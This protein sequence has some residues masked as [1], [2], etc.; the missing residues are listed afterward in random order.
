MEVVIIT[1][2]YEGENR[3]S[4][5]LE[6]PLTITISTIVESLREAHWLSMNEELHYQISLTGEGW[7]DV[8]HQCLL[9]NQVYG[10]GALIRMSPLQLTN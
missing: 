4:I 1:V 7:I 8:D 5:D 10:D 9:S 6:V 2:I 3:A